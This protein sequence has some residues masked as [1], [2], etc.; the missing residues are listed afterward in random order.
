MVV[1][2]FGGTSVGKPAWF[3]NAV[4]IVEEYVRGGE[5]LLVIASALRGVTDRLVVAGTDSGEENEAFLTWLYQT[6]RTHAGTLLDT[7]SQRTFEQVLTV[8]MER[9]TALLDT[10]N[11]QKQGS[12][13]YNAARDELLAV[14]ERLSVQ[15]FSLALTEKGLP[16]LAVDASAFIK[17]DNTHGNAQVNLKDSYSAIASWYKGLKTPCIPVV[18]GFIGSSPEGHTTTLGRGG[19]DYSASILAAGLQADKLERWTDVDGIYTNDPRI[20]NT[21]RK[22]DYIIMEDA[23]SW[24]KA[25]KMG[26]HRKTLDPLIEKRIALQVRSIETPDKPGTIVRPLKYRKVATG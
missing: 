1:L 2:K 26:L 16:G 22:L 5:K 23:L 6:H 17:T 7:T 3:L 14:G 9:V 18:T 13:T 10:I 19:S 21:A 15:I 25:G 24:N 8:Y 11:H 12:L 20:D 4:A